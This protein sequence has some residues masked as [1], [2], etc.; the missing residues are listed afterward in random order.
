MGNIPQRVPLYRKLTRAQ[1]RRSVNATYIKASFLGRLA[2]A[3]KAG[4]AEEPTVYIRSDTMR[5]S[6]L[7]HEGPANGADHMMP[8]GRFLAPLS[9][10]VNFSLSASAPLHYH[11]SAPLY[12]TCTLEKAPVSPNRM[13]PCISAAKDTSGVSSHELHCVARA[14]DLIERQVQTHQGYLKVTL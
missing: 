3:K 6:T 13:S 9:Y 2:N 14:H 10:A 7:N 5:L 8:S 11:T 4:V 1:L 12:C